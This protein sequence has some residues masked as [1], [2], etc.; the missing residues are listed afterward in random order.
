MSV[1]VMG[2][3]LADT[4]SK[5]SLAPSDRLRLDACALFGEAVAT[6]PRRA[7]ARLFRISS[8]SYHYRCEMKQPPRRAA[9]C[10]AAPRR[11]SAILI[12]PILPLSAYRHYY[13]ICFS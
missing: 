2:A 5:V 1:K 6:A 8:P 4:R 7:A 9:L 13:A 3:K 11:E 10:R 12:D